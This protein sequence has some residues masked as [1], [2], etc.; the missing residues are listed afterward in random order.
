MNEDISKIS[1]YYDSTDLKQTNENLRIITMRVINIG[2]D[3]IIKEYYDTNDPLR[4]I[5]KNGVII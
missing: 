5:I 3:H 1:V 4:V 2:N